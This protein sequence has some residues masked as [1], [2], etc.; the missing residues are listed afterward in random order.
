MKSQ[1]TDGGWAYFAGR[2]SAIE[3]TATAIAALYALDVQPEARRRGL[4]FITTM[5]VKGGA[6]KPQP[7]QADP[8]SLSAMA[9]LVHMRCS[10][11]SA[12]GS[13]TRTLLPSSGG[14]SAA[15]QQHQ[16]PAR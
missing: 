13:E 6:L 8:T 15:W 12:L 1:N 2:E 11:G 16:A 14:G 3:P 7:S 4:D 10:G 5:Q 9:G